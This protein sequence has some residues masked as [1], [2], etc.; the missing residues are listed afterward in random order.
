M[1]NIIDTD[2]YAI[3]ASSGDDGG[4][5]EESTVVISASLPQ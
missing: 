2:D 1:Q 4:G 5:G 3:T